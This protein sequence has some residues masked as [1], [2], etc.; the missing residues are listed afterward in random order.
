VMRLYLVKVIASLVIRARGQSLHPM[1]KIGAGCSIIVA[2][3]AF[4]VVAVGTSLLA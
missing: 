2:E 3:S 1:L 4:P